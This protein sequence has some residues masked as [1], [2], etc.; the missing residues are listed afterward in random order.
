M[1]EV[2]ENVVSPEMVAAA[3]ATLTPDYVVLNKD[4]TVLSW[5]PSKKSS[6]N[7]TLPDGAAN[8]VYDRKLRDFADPATTLV[9]LATRAYTHGLNNQ[10]D[11]SMITAKEKADAEKKTFDRVAALH[12]WRNAWLTRALAGFARRAPADIMP[13]YDERTTFAR[14]VAFEQ[15]QAFA[16][17]VGE[18]VGANM[19]GATLKKEITGP[20][21]K[22]SV[23]SLIKMLID[24][25]IDEKTGKPVSPRAAKIWAEADK[26][27][28]D[29]R[30]TE[31]QATAANSFAAMFADDDE[32]ESDDDA[33]GDDDAAD[34]IV[35]PV[36]SPAADETPA[37]TRRNARS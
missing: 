2:H 29:K 14:Q 3:I 21:G 15:V 10:A 31:S 4:A 23:D 26:R 16:S 30:A 11:S 34:G 20:G 22:T 7:N 6:R 5:R 28:A 1:S 19:N 25:S 27:L 17:R 24:E 13:V 12:D 18:S 33:D 35:P 36:E 37:T 8:T 9:E 32:S